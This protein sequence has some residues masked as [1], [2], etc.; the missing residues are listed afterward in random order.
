MNEVDEIVQPLVKTV[1]KVKCSNPNCQKFFAV[2]LY[3]EEEVIRECPNCGKR[4]Y[5]RKGKK[6]FVRSV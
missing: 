1:F 3:H 5:I 4:Y 6:L 2:E